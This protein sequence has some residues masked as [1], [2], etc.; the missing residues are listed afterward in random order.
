VTASSLPK[1]IPAGA[2]E[3]RPGRP[4]EESEFTVTTELPGPQRFFQRESEAQVFERLR[5]ESLSS[6]VGSTRVFFPE[7][8]PLTREPFLPRMFHP[9]TVVVEPSYVCHRRLYFEQQ[10]FERVGWDVGPIEPAI[11][12]GTFYFDIVTFPYQFGT[13]PCQRYDWSAGKCLP[14]DPTPLV[15]YPWEWSLTGALAQAGVVVGG[16]AI[17][18]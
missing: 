9:S 4:K 14:G 3:V 8:E 10:N 1:V 5:R 6:R 2:Q 13:R 7:E 17:F 15:L 18:P 12:L 16:L 11:C